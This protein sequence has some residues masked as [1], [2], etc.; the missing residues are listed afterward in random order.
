MCKLHWDEVA[1]SPHDEWLAYYKL[2]LHTR[3]QR[4]VPHLRSAMR[5]GSFEV[6][7]TNVLRVDWTLADDASLHLLANFDSGR[8]HRAP[9]PAGELVFSTDPHHAESDSY[10]LPPRSAAWLLQAAR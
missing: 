8:A 6:I 1:S 7:G 4:I 3:M 9:R 5:V 2:L 10:L